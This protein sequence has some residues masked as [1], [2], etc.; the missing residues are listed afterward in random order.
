MRTTVRVFPRRTKATPIDD[1]AF[2]RF[3][4]LTDYTLDIEEV[5]VSVSFVEDMEIAKRMADAWSVIAPVSIGGPAT[6]QRGEDFVPGMYLKQGY[7]ITSRGCPNTCP[8]CYVWRREGHTVRE[9]PIT[10]GYNVLDDNFLA[11]SNDH[12]EAVCKMLRGGSQ[13]ALF[14][15]GLEAAR[16]TDWHISKLVDVKPDRMF[17]AYDTPD[18][19]EPLLSAGKRLIDAGFTKTHHL[20]CYVLIGYRDDTLQAAEKRCHEAWAAGFMPMA[21][22]Y[23]DGSPRT[24]DWESLQRVYARPAITRKKLEVTTD[25]S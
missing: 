2:C 23:R 25:A 9:L 7:V 19:Y 16:L 14:T 15:G 17:F 6:G 4:V 20:F 18:D 8:F 12:I 22:L 1:R 5:H 3:P 21:M 11:C 24:R 13:R 10:Q